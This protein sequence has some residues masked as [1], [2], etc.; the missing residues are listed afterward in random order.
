MR[1]VTE[2]LHQ[3]GQWSAKTNFRWPLVTEYKHQDGHTRNIGGGAGANAPPP[4]NAFP[5]QESF[6]YWVE[7][8]QIKNWVRAGENFLLY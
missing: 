5:T 2:S 8:G 7:Q 4:Q 1:L 3:D 6:D